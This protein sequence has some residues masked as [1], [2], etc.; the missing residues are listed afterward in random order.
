MVACALLKELHFIEDTKGINTNLH[1]LRTKDGKEIDFLITQED[2]P[3]TMIEVK[4]SDS[5]PSSN[6]QHFQHFLPNTQAIQLVRN[7]ERNKTY[8]TGLAVQVAIPWLTD[9]GL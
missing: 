1:F 3:T 6:F 8:P 4:W 5:T 7:L 2:I 9:I